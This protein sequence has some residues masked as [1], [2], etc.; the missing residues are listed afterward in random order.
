MA[1]ASVSEKTFEVLGKTL[2]DMKATIRTT[3]IPEKQSLKTV[4]NPKNKDP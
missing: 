4:R 1:T 2:K 3:P